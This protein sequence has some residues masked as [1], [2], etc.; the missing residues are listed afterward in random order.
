MS[1]Q[2]P[3]GIVSLLDANEFQ[4]GREGHALSESEVLC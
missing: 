3:E 2:I 1:R 4:T